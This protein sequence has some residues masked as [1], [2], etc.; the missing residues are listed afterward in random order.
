MGRFLH[1]FQISAVRNGLMFMKFDFALGK[2]M[3]GLGRLEKWG[4]HVHHLTMY[5][6]SS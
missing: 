6:R 1:G 2:V 4:F 5:D 3:E